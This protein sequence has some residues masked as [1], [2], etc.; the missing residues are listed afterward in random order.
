MSYIPTSFRSAM[1][2]VAQSLLPEPPKTKLKFNQYSNEV[3]SING[4]YASTEKKHRLGQSLVDIILQYTG[5]LSSPESRRLEESAKKLG[6]VDVTKEYLEYWDSGQETVLF[7]PNFLMGDDS[8]RANLVYR[9]VNEKW[10]K[11]LGLKYPEKIHNDSRHVVELTKIFNRIDHELSLY[12]SGEENPEDLEL[13]KFKGVVQFTM[14]KYNNPMRPL[15]NRLDLEGT[16]THKGNCLARAIHFLGFNADDYPSDSRYY[17]SIPCES[18]TRFCDDFFHEHTRLQ[19]VIEKGEDTSEIEKQLA[20]IKSSDGYYV[21]NYSSMMGIYAS[22]M[23][24]YGSTMDIVSAYAAEKWT[25]DEADEL[26]KIKSS[27]GEEVFNYR[28]RDV[29]AS[30]LS[31]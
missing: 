8:P 27:D 10:S 21:F 7:T 28:L 12:Q 16:L 19:R 1:S 5:T 15:L 3:L 30:Y 2:F 18:A 22:R 17:M 20:K 25:R 14:D 26:A 6:I 29:V 23:Y 31:D 13:L 11:R 24:K 9:L 4:T